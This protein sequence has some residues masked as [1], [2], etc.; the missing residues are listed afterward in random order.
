MSWLLSSPLA[1]ERCDLWAVVRSN[2]ARSW[3]IYAETRDPEGR[4]NGRTT[5]RETRAVTTPQIV[6][7]G[8][9]Y[10][11]SARHK[12]ISLWFSV[13]SLSGTAALDI[14]YLVA[15][16][17][18]GDTN[19]A[20]SIWSDSLV[21]N[22]DYIEVSPQHITDT[23]PRVAAVDTATLVTTYHL[24]RQGDAFLSSSGTALACL[25]MA[26]KGAHW[27]WSN[28]AGTVPTLTITPARWPAY[29]VPQ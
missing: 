23:A 7:L 14:D 9:V 18:E 3:A 12:G 13:A 15:F 1:R 26:T 2:V 20:L 16:G 25:W 21:K 5:T 27:R 10:S 11:A 24:G 17:L 22:I 8:S 28:A 29:Q 19:R 4:T 6:Y